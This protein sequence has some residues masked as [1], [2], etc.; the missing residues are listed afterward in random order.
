MPVL[1][2]FVLCADPSSAPFDS[3][4]QP[5]SGAVL[6]PQHELSGAP[7][8]FTQERAARIRAARISVE[9]VLGLAL[10]APAEVSGAYFGLSLDIAAGLEIG[11][12]LP[13]GLVLG[14]ALGSAPGV[15]LGGYAMGGDGSF[16]W[17]L[18]GSSLGT[19]LS[20]ALLMIK[21]NVGTIILAALFPV[22][23]ATLGYE[24]S[25]P[26]QRAPRPKK[27]SVAIVPTFSPTSVGLAG[28][29]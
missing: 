26:V 6:D 1:L 27:S 8:P 20:F 19:T 5:A 10:A 21:A 25:S 7:V 3:S 13:I 17:T 11:P 2:A 18:L 28:V 9:A 16:G 24:L 29:F 22:I 12:G 14:A 23:G 15:W 4:S